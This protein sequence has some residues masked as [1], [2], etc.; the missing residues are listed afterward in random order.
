[1]TFNREMLKEQMKDK[2]PMYTMEMIHCSN[3]GATDKI[4]E[5]AEPYLAHALSKYTKEMLL[6]EDVSEDKVEG[7]ANA[8]SIT[9]AHFRV[10]F[11]GG[12]GFTVVSPVMV[13]QGMMNTNPLVRFRSSANVTYEVRYKEYTGTAIMKAK[14]KEVYAYGFG[15]IPPT[16]LQ[17]SDVNTPEAI[18]D[19]FKNALTAGGLK[20]HK[21]ENRLNAAKHHTNKY[22]IE[23]KMPEWEDRRDFYKAMKVHLPSTDEGTITFSGVFCTK[24]DLHMYCGRARVNGN[25]MHCGPDPKMKSKKAIKK[26]SFEDLFDELN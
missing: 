8:D 24:Y 3:M 13:K 5:E 1:M 18:K 15:E 22:I 23:W 26:R 2:C 11:R 21:V 7:Q 10:T 20:W 6:A 17:H 4:H 14:D 9:D 16:A 12:I 19:S 25:C